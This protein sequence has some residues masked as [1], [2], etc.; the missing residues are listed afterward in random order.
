MKANIASI[1]RLDE[2]WQ[3][4]VEAKQNKTGYPKQPQATE[5]IENV[6]WFGAKW[7]VDGVFDNTFFYADH[8]SAN[9]HF[10]SGK[11]IA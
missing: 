6:A 8:A 4:F 7:T 2:Y 10:M 1:G 11:L 3:L 9:R 5:H